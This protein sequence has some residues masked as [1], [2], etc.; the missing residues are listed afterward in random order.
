M[1]QIVTF[2]LSCLLVACTNP[3]LNKLEQ[4]VVIEEGKSAFYDT[5]G[6]LEENTE[7]IAI[8]TPTATMTNEFVMNKAEKVV[9]VGATLTEVKVDKVYKGEISEKITI[10]ESYYLN[11]EEEELA[12]YDGYIPMREGEKYLV[13]MSMQPENTHPALEGSYYIVGTTVGAIPITTEGRA[14]NATFY[15]DTFGR[16]D[17]GRGLLFE[18][19]TEAIEKYL[20]E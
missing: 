6:L 11:T 17:Y 18:I 12:I 2:F 1:K 16:D 4:K 13:F 7:V 14:K 19:Q 5:L 15:K 10:K 8:V 9:E 3:A 20:I